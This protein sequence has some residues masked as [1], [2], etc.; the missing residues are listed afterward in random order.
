MTEEFIDIHSHA[1]F[2]VD[3]GARGIEESLQMLRRM[4]DEGIRKAIL[5][6]HYH[7]GHAQAD[8]SVIQKKF[9]ELCDRAKGD[10][11]ATRGVCIQL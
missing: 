11:N 4:Y 10:D 8:V 1:L 2:G 3:D 5:T 9:D 6:P 7:R